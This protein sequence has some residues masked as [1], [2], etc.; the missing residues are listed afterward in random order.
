MFTED[1]L[2]AL[3]RTRPDAFFPLPPTQASLR[4]R[5]GLP[6]SVSRALRTLNAAD[7]HALEQLADRGAELDP[8]D[9]TG[10][11]LQLER[12]R[13][14]ALIT[15]PADAVRIA[16][17]TLS[18]LPAGWRVSDVA[19]EG[20]REG[21]EKLDANERKV[22]ETLARAG[23]VGT[24]KAAAPDADP[25]TPVARLIAKQ[26]LVRVDGA[27][28]RLPRPV[29][30]ALVGQTPRI[31]PLVEPEQPEV[32]QHAVDEAATA[33]GLEAV[34]QMRQLLTRLLAEPVALNK[35]STVGV[36]ALAALTKELGFDPTFMVTVGESAG[37]IGRGNVDPAQDAD[38]LA[39]TH[40]ALSWLDATLTQQWAIVLAGWVASP[41]RIDQGHKLLSAESHAPDI[42]HARMDILRAGGNLQMLLFQAPLAAAAMRDALINAVVTEAEQVGALALGAASSPLQAV[43]DGGDVAAAATLV[44]PEVDTLIA[45]ADMTV[46]APGPL[47]P[48]VA[49]VLERFADMESPGL[50]SVWRVSEASLRRAFSGG[51]TAPQLHEWLDAH[52]M[53]EVP[54]AL[55]FMVDDVARNHGTIR[56]GQALSYIRSEDPALITRALSL[57]DAL[58]PL[59][60]TAAIAEI[61]LSQLLAQLRQAGLQPVA[62]NAQ[63]AELNIAPEPAL[64]PATPS[65]I[66]RLRGVAD[67]E[68][69]RIVAKL[70]S[71][72]EEPEADG[73]N[74][75]T[76]RAAARGRR[77]VHLGYVDKNGRGRMLTVLPLS[78]SAGQVDALDEASDRVVRI[79]LPRITKVVLA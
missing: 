30:E 24:T 65:T 5:L 3:I 8:V 20:V 25:D 71:P 28:V 67:G 49:R 62:E 19:P 45:Q 58:R 76:L 9:T 43:L 60:P 14:R 27:T 73:D 4:T 48:D 21:V 36:R 18:A 61:P 57:I 38:A 7:L 11:D 77:H 6:G 59:A 68:V 50:A 37:L 17:G 10:L 70:E 23:G 33:Q 22:L 16:A 31:Y 52:V 2:R 29:R 51:M 15:G 69:A 53:G 13:E 32:D 64:V 42:R 40:D 44:P 46:L 39:A 78:V 34:R 74:L 79:A 54:Q 26:M 63:G 66:P 56:A 12:L 72:D 55:S 41:W 47:T 35:D 1:Q 75:E